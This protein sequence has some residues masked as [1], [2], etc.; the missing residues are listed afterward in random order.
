MR[1]KKE[2]TYKSFRFKSEAFILFQLLLTYTNYALGAQTNPT[3]KGNTANIPPVFTQSCP[4]IYLVRQCTV[5]GGTA[6][7]Y[8]N[9]DFRF[10]IRNKL[11]EELYK[12]GSDQ[13]NAAD[14]ALLNGWRRLASKMVV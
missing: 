5:R 3:I 10:K 7:V 11:Q 4:S 13:T 1:N 9:G 14:S 12:I 8:E 2:I 6:L